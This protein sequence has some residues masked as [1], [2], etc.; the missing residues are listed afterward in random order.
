MELAPAPFQLSAM[1]EA[2]AT[3]MTVNAG[4]KDLELAIGVEP[5]VPQ[6]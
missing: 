1:L 3:I 2:I 5:G 6:A 4:E